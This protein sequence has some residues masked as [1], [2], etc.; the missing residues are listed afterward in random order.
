MDGSSS[1]SM[2]SSRGGDVPSTV[3]V[4]LR[5]RPQGNREKLEGSRVCTSVI[6]G[7][8]QVTIG[9][10]RSFTYDHVF[11]Q[12]TQ[13]NEIYDSCIEKLVNGL[14]DGFNATVL[15]YGQ[16]GSGK[17]YTMGTAFDAGAISEHEVGVIPRALAHVFR[18][19]VELRREAQESGIL[20]PTF[21]VSV[22]FIELYNEEIVDLLANDRASS[23][24][25]RI[26]EDARGEIYLHGVTN[27]GVHD[28][29]STLEILKN[30][31]LNRT[32]AATNMNEQSSR[33]HAI[34]SLH[35]KQ[36]RVAVS[37]D[38]PTPGQEIE[39]E[40]LSAKFHFV[41][42]AGSERL[43][44]TGATGDRA[45]EGISINCG[46]LALGNVISALG[47][48]NG[49]VSHVPYRDSKLTRLLQDSLG[50]NSRTLMIACVS[51]SD[52]DF[53]ETLNTMKY[54]N[55]AKNIKNK[56]V[57]NQDKSSKLIGELR[58]R[59]AALEAELLEFKQ[60]RR[61]IDSDGVETVNDQYHENVMLT[62][63]INQL[64]F[65]VKAL[66]ETNEILRNRNVDLMAKASGANGFLGDSQANDE[67]GASSDDA[68][69][70]SANDAVMDP[71]QATLRKY[72]D[73]LERLRSQLYESQAVSNQLRKELTKWKNQA[74]SGGAGFP[75][76]ADHSFSSFGHQQL[77]DEARADI[78][79]LRKTVSVASNEVTSDYASHVDT[80][81][82]D[83][84][85]NDADELDEDEDYD[86]DVD[87]EQV[88][89]DDNKGAV[90]RDNLANLQTEINI[91]E[92][93]I[94][95][96][97]Q[98]DRRLAE[99]RL[100]YEKKL[101]E[102]SA[103]IKKMEAERDKVLM[104][105]EAKKT[106]KA[107]Q[108][109]AK[110]I[111]D[112]YERKL[113]DMRNEFRK[114]Q[115]VEREHKRMQARQERERQELVRYQ[116]ELKEL[117]R[118][119]QNKLFEVDLM[120][121]IKEEMKRAQQQQSSNAKRLAAMDKEARR[122][123][124]LIRQLENKDRQREQFMKRTNEEINRLRK[125]QKEQ[126][127]QARSAASS[128]VTPMRTAQSR[129]PRTPAN[130]GHPPPEVAFS[131][132]QAKMKWTFI[133]KRLNRLVTQKQTVGKMEEEL[134]RQLEERTRLVD[135]ITTLERRFVQVQDVQEREAVADQIDGCHLKLNY[136]QDQITEIQTAIVDMDGSKSYVTER[137]A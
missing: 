57:A 85:S 58:G 107:S 21:D 52:S 101:T 69:D 49:K 39:M 111:R 24:N 110:R 28:L 103:Q 19:I 136:V 27:K 48:A 121:K 75:A 109:Q 66:Q 12:A 79:R 34:F 42:L 22:Q 104:E 87:D 2:L 10:D 129:M 83:G 93:L 61:T 81:E 112:E 131:P 116:A 68:N 97:E 55:R 51:P 60:G 50:G 117:K 90:L 23:L 77:I 72:L 37:A 38:A 8:P 100:T 105:A 125:A 65:R 16:T 7:E 115:M 14:F 1:S 63:E 29:H 9:T 78:E 43:K 70:S 15:A 4:A 89:E 113:S 53:V 130:R 6:P 25:V 46:L 137:K 88:F 40:L 98:S 5:I 47:G 36:Q 71:V 133:E 128:R 82:E 76:S 30:G 59:I 135:E 62:A 102:L 45:K 134:G 95:E 11:D 108:E 74:L 94:A 31:A 67:N 99:V 124:N 92:R 41:D 122:R 106:D 127:R 18:R 44:R 96:L 33:S 32:V 126:A 132:K 54:A 84:T 91:K 120:K 119:K 80:A 20:E 118:V 86:Q 17:T 3:Q 56:V 35:I 123:D 26:H 13:Q 114:L 73:E 64:R